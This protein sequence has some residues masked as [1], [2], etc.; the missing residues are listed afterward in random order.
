MHQVDELLVLREK[1][2]GI[3]V[4][5]AV[6]ISNLIEFLEN[7]ENP[8]ATSNGGIGVESTIAHVL[9]AHLRKI[10]SNHVR[11][12]GSV[13]GN[14]MMARLY[15]FESDIATIFLGVDAQVT[16]GGLVP[17]KLNLEDFLGK[18]A[19]EN[20]EVLQSIW[21]P[22]E[23]SGVIFKSFRAAP[24]PSGFALAYLNAA[25][26]ARVTETDRG[27]ALGDVRLAFGAFGTDH[28]IRARRVENHL[29]GKSLTWEV[30]LEAV[31]LLKV[32]VVPKPGT[33]KAE[34]RVSVAVSFLFQFLAPFL[35]NGDHVVSKVDGLLSSGKQT[36]TMT[37][38]FFPVGQP[39]AKIASDLQA[40]GKIS[41]DSV[42]FFCFFFQFHVFVMFM[43]VFIDIFWLC[44]CLCFN[45]VQ[46]R[47]CMWTIFRHR[48]IAFRWH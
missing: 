37:D 24:R 33:R 47:L 10:A 4:G 36:I 22:L 15:K 11:N 25:F 18:G 8:K 40:S 6:T 20:G 17:R 1:A 38:E 35:C 44:F 21:I 28:A 14:L 30:I 23:S 45:Y 13:G 39:S 31:Q 34:Y 19:L 27:V 41:C 48:R 32:E 5:A 42:P 46:V 26:F 3:K 43:W 7:L 29:N 2:G 16:V 9:A 12:W